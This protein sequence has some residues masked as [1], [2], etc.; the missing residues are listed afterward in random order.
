[1]FMADDTLL[2]LSRILDS[3]EKVWMES[4]RE[5]L[6]KRIMKQ[7]EAAQKSFDKSISL[8][9]LCK[10]WGGPFVTFDEFEKA[11]LN[12]QEDEKQVKKVLKS[13]ISYRKL[14]SGRDVIIRPNLYRLNK[15]PIATLKLNLTTLISTL[16]SENTAFP[17]ED[18]IL[19][20]IKELRPSR[21]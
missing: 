6:R 12:M 21:E 13:E 11:L 16:S 3:R 19:E 1:M 14:I 4:Q 5:L 9:A 7:Q 20:K 10:S 2:K 15:I 17:D 18:D 8:L